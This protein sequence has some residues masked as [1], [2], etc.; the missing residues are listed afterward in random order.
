MEGRGRYVNEDKK[1]PYR[2]GKIME[3]G[4]TEFYEGKT[5]LVIDG[6]A[7]YELDEECLKRKNRD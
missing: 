2:S 6:N 4:K 1:N 3:E 5:T 7:V